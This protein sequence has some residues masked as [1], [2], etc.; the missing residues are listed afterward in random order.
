MNSKE[1]FNL[2]PRADMT[3]RYYTAGGIS[4]R[5]FVYGATAFGSAL[6]TIGM[7]AGDGYAQPRKG[8]V[9]KFGN[10]GGSPEDNLDP[11]KITDGVVVLAAFATYNLLVEVDDNGKATPELAE[12]WEARPGAVTWI[13][14]IRKGVSFHNGKELD[15]DDVIYSLN[16][17]RGDSSSGA[18][19]TLS[20]IKSIRKVT[21]HQLEFTLHEANADMPYTLSDFHLMIV[22]DGWTDWL[23]PVGTGAF[24]VEGFKPGVSASG[25]RNPNYWKTGRGHVDRYEITVINSFEKRLEA[26]TNGDVHLINRVDR[27][28]VERIKANPDLEIARSPGGQHFTL[29]MQCH[30]PPFDNADLRKALKYSINREAA[31]EAIL[32]GY[33]SVGNDHPI[34][35]HDPNF[36]SELPVRPYDPEK[37]RFYLKKAGFDTLTVD[38]I[39]SPA[40]FPE[41]P[42]TAE[43]YKKHAKK[44]GI[45]INVQ[46]KP[47]HGY[48]ND[49]WMKVPFCMSF[50]GGRATSDMMLSTAYKSDSNWNDTFWRREDF[51]KLLLEAR[52]MLDADKRRQIYWDLQKMIHDDGGNI[53]PMFAEFVDCRRTFIKGLTPSPVFELSGLRA[54]ERCWIDA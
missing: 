54:A 51:D 16:L 6:A 27:G 37:G 1:G 33:G 19:S 17:H 8:G 15:A 22:P 12:S 31:V 29:L 4:R 32:H 47:S 43:L 36:N 11:R 30:Q 50:W 5:T 9:L 26:L 34:P 7:G 2:T 40:A 25:N 53:V 52:G 39:T 42:S 20:G 10:A 21:P 45:D 23:K 18:K 14:N 3:H 44:S 41:A 28:S 48:W 24:S 13:F 35:K 46:V 38:L 49:V